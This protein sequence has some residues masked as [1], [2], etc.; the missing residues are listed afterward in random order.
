[1]AV[2][3]VVVGILLVL[4]VLVLIVGSVIND[5]DKLVYCISL[6]MRINFVKSSEDK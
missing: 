5:E 4:V 3:V 1:M 6:T 2:V